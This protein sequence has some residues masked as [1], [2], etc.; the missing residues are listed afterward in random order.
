MRALISIVAFAVGVQIALAA[1]EAFDRLTYHSPPKPLSPEAVTEDWP[2]FLGLR[3]DLHSKETR[4]LKSFPDV[5]PGKVWEVERG[6]GHA[7]VVIAGDYLVM[8]HELDGREM[9]EC[10]HPETGKRYWKVDYPVQLGS[11]YGIRDAPRA[12]PVIDGDL[13]FAVG[14]Q[15]DLHCLKL[16]SGELVWKKDLDESF[17]PAPLF[18]GRG[19]CP[20]VI[21]DQL[22]V[23]VGGDACVASFNKRTG[24]LLWKTEHE[25]HASYAS[26][27][28]AEINGLK[29]VMVFAGGM[30]RPP[31]GGL[32]SIDPSNGEIEAAIPWRAQMFA[33]V[34]AASPVVVENGVF[35]TEA[36]TEGGA[37][38]DFAKGGSASIRWKA[39]RF[40][41]QFTTPVSHDGY[42][43]GVHGT[44]GTEI[45]CYEIESG[46]E[47]WRD[48]IDLEN[49]RLGRASLLHVDGAF[50]CIGDQGT[51]IWLDLSPQEAKIISQTQLFRAPETWGIPTVSKGLL[52]VNQNAMGSRLIC[53]DLRGE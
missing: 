6:S 39:E 35:I 29:R 8:I 47:M 25:W 17:G 5:G 27:V 37:L 51:L 16:R 38:I 32:L 7:P 4:L 26:P 14:V 10:L 46:K 40:G 11:N 28:P 18:F 44:G 49:A 36:Y 19:S 53:Y 33:S 48:G 50:L 52:F 43:Y 21:E 42:L 34:N 23:N 31:T 22:I 20:L 30:V 24:D 45:V 13:V 41:S 15:S 2:R 12:G 9:I 3:H 1:P